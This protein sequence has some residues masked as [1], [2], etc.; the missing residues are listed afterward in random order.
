MRS[1]AWRTE[2]D[3]DRRICCAERRERPCTTSACLRACVLLP[4]AP[5]IHGRDSADRPRGG[6][7][8]RGNNNSERIDADPQRSPSSPVLFVMRTEEKRKV[9]WG[10]RGEKNLN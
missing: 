6:T 5:N 4:A 2:H 10:V 7:R 9:R 3:K 1:T 8:D